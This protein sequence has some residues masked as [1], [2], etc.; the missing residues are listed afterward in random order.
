MDIIEQKMARR[1]AELET[2][3]LRNKTPVLEVAHKGSDQGDWDPLNEGDR[4]GGPDQYETWWVPVDTTIVDD[5]SV[6][7]I[8]LTRNSRGAEALSLYNGRILQGVDEH[9]RQVI[10]PANCDGVELRVWSGLSSPFHLRGSIIV[11]EREPVADSLFF[12]VWNAFAVMKQLSPDDPLKLR[13]RA[14]LDQAL[15]NID[16]RVPGS[17]TF[18][19]SLGPVYADLRSG[20]KM[21]SAKIPLEIVA[22]GHAH[23][24]VAWLWRVSH[25][26]EKAIRTF[27]TALTLMREYPEYRFAQSQAQLYD[28]VKSDAPEIFEEI[29]RRVAEGRWEPVGAMWVE[30]DCNLLSGE[31]LVRQILYGSQFFREEFGSST[32][33]AWL[34]DSFGFNAQMPQILRRSGISAFVTTK[35]SWNQ[36]NRMP[37]DTFWWRGIDGSRVLALFI[38]T[39]TE[40]DRDVYATYNGNITAETVKG[41][42]ERYQDK[43]INERLL[44]AFGWG[45]GGGGPTREMLENRRWLN[46]LPGVP[47]VVPG[48][49]K[50]YFIE[51]HR[52]VDQNRDVA[53]WSGELYLE[54]HRGTYTSQAV[55]KRLNRR[56][57]GRLHDAEALESLVAWYDTPSDLALKESWK[58]VLRNQFHDILPGSAIGPVY[59]DVVSENSHLLDE[60]S[61]AVGKLLGGR[62]ADLHFE[63]TTEP[64]IYRVFNTLGIGRTEL[65]SIPCVAVAENV[66]ARRCDTGE[67]LPVQRIFGEGAE[68]LLVALQDIPSMGGVD[69]EIGE[70]IVSPDQ[71][72]PL[73][74]TPNRLETPWLLLEFNQTGNLSRIYDRVANRDVLP[75]GT[76]GNVLRVFEDKPLQFDAWDIDRFYQ[77]KCWTVHEVAWVKVKETGP[78][79][80]AIEWAWRYGSS[81]IRQTIRVYAHEPRV[82]FVT[83][84]DWHEHQQL[85]KVEFPVDVES[86]Y[87]RSDIQFGNLV[88]PIHEN[89][90]WDTARFET[91]AHTWADISDGGFGVSLLNDC[92][93][94]HDLRYKHLGLSLIKS[95]IDPDPDADQGHHSFTYT[96]LAHRGTFVD[97][98][99][100]PTA[101]RLNAPCVVVRA[102][103]HLS[104][105]MGE[106]LVSCDS[107]HVWLETLKRAEDQD[108]SIIRLYEFGGR[109]GSAIVRMASTVV[110]VQEVT[111]LEVPEPTQDFIVQDD[112]SFSFTVKPYEIRSFRVRTRST[113]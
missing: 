63:P 34:P 99:V 48:S 76:L 39:P 87:G 4:W 14:L 105:P 70:A 97:G 17:P 64:A 40:N 69:I 101:K 6:L 7:S 37:H 23:I 20:L 42:W 79:R 24:D 88:R 54:Y 107:D 30:S 53:V 85:L 74:V 102:S 78:L 90:S 82:D 47:A 80:G 108:G 93:Y 35:L 8:E 50:D 62:S 27:S 36:T 9:H 92:K 86:D 75:N 33:V 100:H 12:A 56:I 111:L 51:V 66:G 104:V 68:E 10:I 109:Q 45:D 95:S 61:K 55:V 84:V 46:E 29:R 110:D 1:I 77:D 43:A 28:F 18:Y 81:L 15:T 38:T 44:L 103:D 19:A 41:I 83:D 22:I 112:H 2:W 60:L 25:T 21:L 89:T 52:V 106:A 58:T 49:V 91:V 32:M 65:V 71:Q 57:E 59:R 96:L 16:W 11:A 67:A 31:S 98:Q 72:N 94:G 13:Y 5:N 26:R 113:S 3:R 73:Q